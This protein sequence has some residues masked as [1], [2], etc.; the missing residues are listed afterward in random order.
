MHDISVFHL[1][2]NLAQLFFGCLFSTAPGVNFQASSELSYLDS[3]S[4]VL[5]KTVTLH[6]TA[7]PVLTVAASN[8][9]T[10]VFPPCGAL[11]F[12]QS[13]PEPKA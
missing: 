6:L 5:W 2:L 9:E 1:P 8:W 4:R 3:R 7:W 10:L 11:P 12:L 13:C